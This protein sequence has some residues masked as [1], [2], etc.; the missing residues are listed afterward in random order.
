MSSSC[1]VVS[2]VTAGAKKNKF[3]SQVFKNHKQ[4]HH[5]KINPGNL[6]VLDICSNSTSSSSK[7]FSGR[8]CAVTSPDNCQ[9]FSARADFSSSSI[10][11]DIYNRVWSSNQN[12]MSTVADWIQDF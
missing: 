1:S 5:F 12:I 7:L 9:G 11:F 8:A 4:F 3:M 6:P 10:F 2:S